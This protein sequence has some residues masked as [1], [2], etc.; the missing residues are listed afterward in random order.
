MRSLHLYVVKTNY[1]METTAPAQSKNRFEMTPNEYQSLQKKIRE[2][3]ADFDELLDAIF[4]DP[5]F[6]L[7]ETMHTIEAYFKKWKAEFRNLGLPE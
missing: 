5:G 4:A 2:E 3:K 6:E 1:T 7:R